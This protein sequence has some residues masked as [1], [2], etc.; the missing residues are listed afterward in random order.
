M[1]YSL[2]TRTEKKGKD[3]K[4]MTHVIYSQKHIRMIDNLSKDPVVKIDTTE[5]GEKSNK[6]G[7]KL[8]R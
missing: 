1:E 7:K 5:K 6:K 3:K 4:R 8:K 2:K